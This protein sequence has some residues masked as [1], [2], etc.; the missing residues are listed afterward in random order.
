MGNFTRL[1]QTEALKKVCNACHEEAIENG[2]KT[3]HRVLRQVLSIFSVYI[4]K[5]RE[6]P[7]H[8]RSAAILGRRRG[9][10]T[11]T[12]IDGIITTK[13]SFGNEIEI[14]RDSKRPVSVATPAVPV[15]R[16]HEKLTPTASFPQSIYE[17]QSSGATALQKHRLKVPPSASSQPSIPQNEQILRSDHLMVRR[18]TDGHVG[19]AA[20]KKQKELSAPARVLLSLGDSQFSRDVSGPFRFLFAM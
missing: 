1:G 6:S 17:S 14:S 7:S 3:Y 12:K 13:N 10:T 20:G 19:A 9:S 11:S 8:W 18:K 4:A 15:V 2:A 5:L 16:V